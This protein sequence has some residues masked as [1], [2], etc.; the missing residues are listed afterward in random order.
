MQVF[1]IE[2]SKSYEEITAEYH[3]YMNKKTSGLVK[4]IVDSAGTA[5]TKEELIVMQ[6]K[7]II[8]IMTQ[9]ALGSPLNQEVRNKWMVI[10]FFAQSTLL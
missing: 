4:E 8:D 3:E 2:N 10:F 9:T 6:K 5:K 7:I 1:F